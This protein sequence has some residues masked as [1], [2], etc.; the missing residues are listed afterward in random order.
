[1][2][3][4]AEIGDEESVKEAIIV[5]DKEVHKQGDVGGNAGSGRVWSRAGVVP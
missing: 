5:N 1:M 2:A 3:F 4:A